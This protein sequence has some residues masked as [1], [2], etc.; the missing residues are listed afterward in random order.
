[1]DLDGIIFLPV[2]IGHSDSTGVHGFCSNG[3]YGNITDNS[4]YS[5]HAILYF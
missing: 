2:S 3:R 4:I 5:L 1:M